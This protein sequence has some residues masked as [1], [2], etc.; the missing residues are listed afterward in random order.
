MPQVTWPRGRGGWLILVRLFRRL[1]LSCASAS[2]HLKHRPLPRPPNS[3][4]ACYW[5]L[6][7]IIMIIIII[8]IWT[9]P[10]SQLQCRESCWCKWVTYPAA[11][12]WATRINSRV[13]ACQNPRC[14]LWATNKTFVACCK[15]LFHELFQLN[16]LNE[17]SYRFLHFPS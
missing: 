4:Q 10:S 17:C 2:R 13:P 8:M 12:N 5:L 11:A 6:R 3:T 9:I 15:E 16:S 1:M 7:I 14:L